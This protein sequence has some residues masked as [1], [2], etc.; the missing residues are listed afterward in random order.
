MDVLAALF[1]I[2]IVLGV[3]LVGLISGLVSWSRINGLTR[4]VEELEA[5]QLRLNAELQRAQHS[6]A[7]VKAARP[8]A[9]PARPRWPARAWCACSR[10]MAPRGWRH[11]WWCC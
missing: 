1:G 3:P 4:R 11:R 9:A 7:G 6:L 2:L 5:E 8:A 10:C